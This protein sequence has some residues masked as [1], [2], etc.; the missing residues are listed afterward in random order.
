MELNAAVVGN[1]MEID[2]SA[3]G[4]ECET[5]D[6]YALTD[7]KWLFLFFAQVSD[8]AVNRTIRYMGMKQR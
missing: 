4:L 3:P 6:F 1:A 7:N 8:G 5:I 2:L